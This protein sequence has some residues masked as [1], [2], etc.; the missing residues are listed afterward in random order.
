PTGIFRIEGVSQTYAQ[1]WVNGPTP[2]D[3]MFAD[4]GAWAYSPTNSGA[5]TNTDNSTNKS[6]GDPISSTYTVRVVGAGS[7]RLD[8]LINDFS[9]SSFH[10][11][12]DYGTGVE[13]V[14]YVRFNSVLAADLQITNTDGTTIY[15][16]GSPTTYT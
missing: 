11:N 3:R 6:G 2:N 4:A 1:P 13:G 14:D 7:G 16:P 8:S 5:T 10:Y 15:T 12:G 9:G